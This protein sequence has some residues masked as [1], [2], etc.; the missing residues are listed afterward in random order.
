MSKVLDINFKNA[1]FK[2]S[3]HMAYRVNGQGRTEKVV[4]GYTEK[5]SNTPFAHLLQ[6]R[7]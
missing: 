4:V 5:F 1:R 7:A 6:V 2:G 3:V